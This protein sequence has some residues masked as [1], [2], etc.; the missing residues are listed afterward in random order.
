M[1]WSHAKA[2]TMMHTILYLAI[3]FIVLSIRR[4]DKSLLM[5]IKEDSY[6]VTYVFVFSIIPFHV[7]LMYIKEIQSLIQPLGIYVD[8]IALEIGDWIICIIA[9]LI[10]LIVLET[11]KWFNRVRGEYY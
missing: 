4:I 9:A 7:I 5:A 2:R 6:W 1:N 8:I 11:T 10:P 3:P